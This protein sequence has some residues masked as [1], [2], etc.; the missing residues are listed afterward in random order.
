MWASRCKSRNKDY[1]FYDKHFNADASSTWKRWGTSNGACKG[2]LIVI[3]RDML[4]DVYGSHAKLKLM[5]VS[6]SF[7][8][9]Y[10]QLPFIFN[11][12]FWEVCKLLKI[13]MIEI[14]IYLLTFNLTQHFWVPRLLCCQ[15]ESTV[16]E[17][18][19]DLW[20]GEV[21]WSFYWNILDEQLH[22][23]LM[24]SFRVNRKVL[25]ANKILVIIRIFSRIRLN[26]LLFKGNLFKKTHRVGNFRFI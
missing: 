19:Y 2:K 8:C 16:L 25:F 10:W 13:L 5:W 11:A 6:L 12:R 4:L 9:C 24:T 7:S 3:W 26:C 1:F 15:S 20:C 23:K 18:F 21:K 17:K 22:K 14:K